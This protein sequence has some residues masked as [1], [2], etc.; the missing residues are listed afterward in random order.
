M[1]ILFLNYTNTEGGAAIAST[2][3]STALIKNYYNVKIGVLKGTNDTLNVINL[4]KKSNFDQILFFKLVRKLYEKCIHYLKKLFKKKIQ[5]SNIIIHSENKKTLINLDIIN[6]SDFDLVHFHWINNDMISIEDI[7]KIKKPIVWTIH[8]SWVFCGA[9][10][11]PNVLENDTRYIHGYLKENKPKTTCGTDVCRKTWERKKKSWKNIQ[12]NFISPSNFEK[13]ALYE[14]ALF[15]NS[16][17][18]CTVIPNFIPGNIFRPMDKQKLKEIYQI[19]SSKKAI[20]FGAAY[21]VT[22]KKSIKGEYLLIETLKKFPNKSNYHLVIFGKA[23]NTILNDIDLPVFATGFISN[24]Q[25]LA[26]VYNLCDVFVCPS[27]IENLPNVCLESLFCGVPVTAFNTG[28]IPDIVEHKKTG[29]LS[30]CF[31]T[32]DLYNGILYCIN[33]YEELSKKSL[34]KANKEFNEN[35]IIKRHIEL[36]ESVLKNKGQLI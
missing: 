26:S 6:N 21:K 15:K 11:H 1:K 4:I 2:R 32:D 9:E 23:D 18:N 8:D 34:I 30:E 28:G 33:N 29:Y 16:S 31:N 35:E 7:A 25:I 27:L 22:N 10:H 36:Y 19:P 13:I 24:P 14:S 5:T 12:F 17:S 3:L 20:G